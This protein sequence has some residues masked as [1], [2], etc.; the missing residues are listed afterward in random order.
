MLTYQWRKDGVPLAT[1]GKKQDL[2]LF[3]VD[4]DDEGVYDCAVTARCTTISDPA[5][6]TVIHG[7]RAKHVTE[8]VVVK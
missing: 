1:G 3:D 5:T 8:P 4:P 6:L 2:T 7:P